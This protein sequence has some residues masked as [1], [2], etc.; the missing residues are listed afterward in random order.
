MFAPASQVAAYVGDVL[1]GTEHHAQFFL[2]QPSGGGVR[3]T[4][5]H[6][7]LAP[8]KTDLEGADYIGS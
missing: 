8:A 7:N 6:A 5:V 3:A 2:V 4:P 1:V